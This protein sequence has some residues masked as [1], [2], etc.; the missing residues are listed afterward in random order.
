MALVFECQEVEVEFR[1]VLGECLAE[2]PVRTVKDEVDLF[3]NPTTGR[4]IYI[5]K[6]VIMLFTLLNNYRLSPVSSQ[7]LCLPGFT[8]HYN[9]QAKQL[10]AIYFNVKGD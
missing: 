2:I 9:Y 3:L 6:I 8:P 5:L 1:P 7:G 10:I 4:Y